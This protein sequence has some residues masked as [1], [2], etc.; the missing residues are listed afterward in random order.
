MK[1][2]LTELR[3]GWQMCAVALKGKSQ[4]GTGSRILRYLSFLSSGTDPR[5]IEVR[6]AKG[7][8]GCG[9]EQGVWQ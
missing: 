3:H 7:G 4:G 5:E 9:G 6:A 2:H 8:I 1:M